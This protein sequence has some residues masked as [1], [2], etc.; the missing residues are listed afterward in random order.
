MY[1]FNGIVYM[2]SLYPIFVPPFQIDYIT[3]LPT[4]VG[5]YDV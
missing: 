4:R 2:L 1:A 3:Y 5:F